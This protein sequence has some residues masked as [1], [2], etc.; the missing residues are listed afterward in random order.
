MAH[1]IE[2]VAPTPLVGVAGLVLLEYVGVLTLADFTGPVTGTAYTFGTARRIGYVD[3]ADAELMK[4]SMPLVDAGQSNGCTPCGLAVDE[5]AAAVGALTDGE[6][7][8]WL[9]AEARNKNRSGA[10]F[11]IQREIDRRETCPQ[12]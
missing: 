10:V 8:R 2:R 9:D 6:L 7:E 5:V 11:A 3:A 4:A 1:R 12:Q